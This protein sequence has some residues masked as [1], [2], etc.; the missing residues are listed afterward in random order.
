MSDTNPSERQADALEELA[1]QTRV[2][3]ALLLE[4][5]HQQIR[6]RRLEEGELP[7]EYSEPSVAKAVED[8]VLELTERVTLDDVDAVADP[9]LMTDGGIVG[10][11]DEPETPEHECADC[12]AAYQGR[13]AALECC[14]DRVGGVR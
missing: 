7:H 14:S 4:L 1:D 13:G 8:R 5:V 6:R 12:G 3:N 11:N 10:P 2:Q 9:D